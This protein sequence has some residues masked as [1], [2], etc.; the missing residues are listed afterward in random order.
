MGYDLS[1]S[2]SKLNL[3]RECPRCFWD[4]NTLKVERPRG[5]FPTLPNGIDRTMKA[6]F[7]QCRGAL[8]AV[9]QG[10]VPGVLYHDI[11]RMQKMRHWKSGLKA[12]VE[13]HGIRVGLIGALDD[14]LQDC[15]DFSTFD[16]KSKGD[17]PK[18]DGSKYYSTQSHIYGLLLDQ[19]GYSISGTAYFAYF[20][21]TSCCG[22][23]WDFDCDVYPLESNPDK[24][25]QIIGEAV[26]LLQGGQP[27]PNLTC[28]YCR[29]AQA[30]V[31]AAL[32]VVAG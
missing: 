24:A 20:W 2:A 17:K 8:P 28:E 1:L 6:C 18:D 12:E 15:P 5:A 21:P 4:A 29:F 27:E 19:N 3:F 26:A 31:D 16:G 11:D 23:S 22:T 32:A 10:K 25:V 13:V 30:R 9:L 7:D 14:L